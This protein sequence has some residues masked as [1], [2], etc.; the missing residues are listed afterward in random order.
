M[1]RPRAAF[2]YAFSLIELLV[3]IAIIAILIGLLLPAVQKVREAAART[4]CQNNL[5]QIGL[6][7]H[8]YHDTYNQFAKAR[9]WITPPAP[10]PP[11]T[12]GLS[13]SVF[14]SLI[15]PFVEQE[16]LRGIY[17]LEKGFDHADNQTAVNT[18]IAIYLC[19]SVPGDRKMQLMNIFADSYGGTNEIPGRT[20]EATDYFGVRNCRDVNH[21]RVGTGILSG[22]KTIILNVTD[23]TSNT[24]LVIEKAGMPVR[25][26]KGRP[27]GTPG[28]EDNWYG[29]WAGDLG[30]ANKLYTV[31]AD[32]TYSTPGPC[33]MNCVNEFQPYSFHKDGVNLAFGDG[34]V[35]FVRESISPTNF[36]RLGTMNDGEAIDGDF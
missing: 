36:Y 3:V 34:S 1:I 31:N 8:G 9:N 4:K 7:S 16:S 21:S 32:F 11:G 2:R 35:R 18:K 27:V 23:G 5:K 13:I 19:P 17:D 33:V 20:G 30:V 22:N 29:P 26:V 25:Y 28:G 24:I 6:A 12:N 10:L 14:L 15:L